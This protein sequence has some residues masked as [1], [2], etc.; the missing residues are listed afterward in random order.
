MHT[1]ECS[2]QRRS[3]ARACLLLL[4]LLFPLLPL[5]MHRA[6]SSIRR[7]HVRLHAA[8]IIRLT[9][10]KSIYPTKRDT[11]ISGRVC[12]SES[13]ATRSAKENAERSGRYKN[14][15]P[16]R[17]RGKTICRVT[18]FFG[19][20]FD[21]NLTIFLRSFCHV[22]EDQM[23]SIVSFKISVVNGQGFLMIC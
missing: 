23:R 2:I 18:C 14:S 17:K 22:L 9:H 12:E 5:P 4:H 8:I 1:Q 15:G 13:S 21:F 3:R 19:E 10:V 16:T 11:V 7:S 6:R 20:R